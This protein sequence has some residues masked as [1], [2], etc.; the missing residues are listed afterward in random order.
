MNVLL[1]GD[2]TVADYPETQRP[3]TGW[4]QALKLLAER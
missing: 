2:S 1:A 4:G 3:M